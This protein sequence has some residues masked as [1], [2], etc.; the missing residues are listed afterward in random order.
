MSFKE[1]AEHLGLDQES[2]EWPKPKRDG[3][4]ENLS[5]ESEEW[6]DGS[7]ESDDVPDS[8]CTILTEEKLRYHDRQGRTTWNIFTRIE[9]KSLRR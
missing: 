8:L 5:G 2:G 9:G 3:E 7:G 6:N 4:E 1:E